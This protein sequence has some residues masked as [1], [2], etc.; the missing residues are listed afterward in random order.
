[1][2]M[3]IIQINEFKVLVSIIPLFNFPI[4]TYHNNIRYHP[5]LVYEFGIANRL[6]QILH[7]SHVIYFNVLCVE[8]ETNI[9]FIIRLIRNDSFN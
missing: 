7:Y 5:S 3:T 9:T 1:M 8:Y 2:T 4:N 6:C